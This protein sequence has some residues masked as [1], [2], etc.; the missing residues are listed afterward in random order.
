[1]LILTS[2]M[3]MPIEGGVGAVDHDASSI[4]AGLVLIFLKM[5]MT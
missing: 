2:K 3:V 4:D 5:T 1:M